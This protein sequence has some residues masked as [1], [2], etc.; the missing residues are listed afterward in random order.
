MVGYGL[1]LT[2]PPAGSVRPWLETAHFRRPD[3]Q[4]LADLPC[5]ADGWLLR[6]GVALSLS[7]DPDAAGLHG[8]V[9]AGAGAAF[10]QD[11]ALTYFVGLGL[12]W[13]Q[14]PRVS[15][16]AEIRWEQIGGITLG[17][18]ALGVRVDL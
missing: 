11:T 1:R 8:A 2:G 18:L 4:C 5:T 6:G 7:R 3:L 17:M 16:T 13:R 10:A 14:L 9:S 12:H 15:P